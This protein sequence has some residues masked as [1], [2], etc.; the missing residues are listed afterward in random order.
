MQ[1]RGM[2]HNQ[3]DVLQGRM[4]ALLTGITKEQLLLSE[5]MPI[6]NDNHGRYVVGQAGVH[7]SSER[8]LP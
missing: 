1:L 2:T 4:G 8:D 6:I 3:V 7:G 5:N